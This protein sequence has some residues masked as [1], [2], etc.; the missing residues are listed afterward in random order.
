MF[1]MVRLTAAQLCL[2]RMAIYISTLC[3]ISLFPSA[4][5]VLTRL[6]PPDLH[7][8]SLTQTTALI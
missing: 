3:F 1:F 6:L 8:P 7:H 4:L 5:L 2:K